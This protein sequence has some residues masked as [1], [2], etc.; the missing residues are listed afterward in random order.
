[1]INKNKFINE[2]EEKN[3]LQNDNRKYKNLIIG[4]N[5]FFI[6]LCLIQMQHTYY[7]KATSD[8]SYFW[9]VFAVIA[10]ICWFIYTI[11]NK[12][13]ENFITRLV[14]MLFYSSILVIK[15]FFRKKYK[16]IFPQ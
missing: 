5:I 8:F 13:Y 16:L 4:T 15:L 6:I 7:T 14:F 12:I 9:L 10:N 2:Y 3:I 11:R 1:M